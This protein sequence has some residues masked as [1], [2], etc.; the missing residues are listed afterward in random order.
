MLVRFPL[1]FTKG[2]SLALI[3]WEPSVTLFVIGVVYGF[4]GPVEWVVRRV[5]GTKL[6]ELPPPESPAS[7]EP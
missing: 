4:S 3:V 7:P 1:I 6:E 2:L 5:R